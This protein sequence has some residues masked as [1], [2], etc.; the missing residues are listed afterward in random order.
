MLMSLP[1]ILSGIIREHLWLK[2]LLKEEHFDRVVSDN[3]FGLWNRRVESVYIT[4][5]LRVKMPRNFGWLEP[6]NVLLH[7]VFINRY[8]QCWIP[9]YEGAENLSGD[10]SHSIKLASN[11]RY[12]GPLSRF[13][14]L[15]KSEAT[16][17]MYDWVIIISGPEPQRTLFE[18]A[19]T[20]EAIR[21]G[22]KTL[23]VRGL[24]GSKDADRQYHNIYITNHLAD[25][26]F[27]S[28]LIHSKKIFCRSGYSTL[29]DL[30][31][32][33]CLHKAVFIPT[34]GQT[35]QEYLAGYH[36]KKPRK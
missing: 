23:L 13:Q 7:R 20:A 3:R 17:E 4:H 1:A 2:R 24:P 30:D 12:I 21:S 25:D 22:E 34:P 11:C 36:Q 27:A 8:S 19:M 5:Q 6:V 16:F 14:D 35:E 29:M 15:Q 26:A 9:D 18:A 31:A 10:L 28:V 32:L 33:D